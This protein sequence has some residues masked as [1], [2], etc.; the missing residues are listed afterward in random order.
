MG[1]ATVTVTNLLVLSTRNPDEDPCDKSV[2]VCP[3]LNIKVKG[4]VDS[5]KLAPLGKAPS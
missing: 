4:S 5:P 3:L 1:S 2:V